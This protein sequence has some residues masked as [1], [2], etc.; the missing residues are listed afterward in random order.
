M[1]DWM[2]YVYQQQ[3]KPA[4]FTGVDVTLNVIDANGNYRTIGT[5]TTDASGYYSCV[6]TPDISGKY[7]VIA[8]FAG[9]NGYWPSSQE[10]SFNIQDAPATPTPMPTA[11]P[12]MSDLYFLPAVLGIIVA[13]IVG[14]VV[15]ALLMLRKHP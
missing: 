13:M 1:S 10:T 14:F 4:N 3:P 12:S 7:T 15:L 2:A 9:T 11:A 5:A 6:W 8:T